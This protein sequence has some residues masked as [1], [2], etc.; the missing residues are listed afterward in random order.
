MYKAFLETNNSSNDIVEIPFDEF[1]EIKINPSSF[2]E[3]DKENIENILYDYFGTTLYISLS[4]N[5][6]GISYKQNSMDI[7]INDFFL[8]IKEEVRSNS[9]DFYYTKIDIGFGFEPFKLFIKKYSKLK[10]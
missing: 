3:R 5:Y 4:D 10:K 7:I 1:D 8:Y 9:I 2:T 6:I